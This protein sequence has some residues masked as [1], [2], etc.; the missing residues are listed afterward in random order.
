MSNEKLTPKETKNV[1]SNIRNIII[2]TQNKIVRIINSAIVES[3]LK[4][5]ERI[6][7]KL[8]TVSVDKSVNN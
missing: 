6:Y 7:E 5:G 8:S 1:Y 4:I 2:D 3:Y